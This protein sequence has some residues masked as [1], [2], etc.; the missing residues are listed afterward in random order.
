MVQNSGAAIQG[1]VV[2][3]ANPSEKPLASWKNWWTTADLQRCVSALRQ[4]VVPSSMPGFGHLIKTSLPIQS[5]DFQCPNLAGASEAILLAYP[6]SRVP[7]A[8]FFGDAIMLYNQLTNYALLGPPQPNPVKEQARRDM[9]LAEGKKLALVLSYL[10]RMASK[11]PVGS[12]PS[13]TYLKSLVRPRAPTQC[14][15][16]TRHL[17]GVEEADNL[18]CGDACENGKSG[19]TEVEPGDA[20]GEP[21]D[22]EDEGFMTDTDIGLRQ[23]DDLLGISAVCDGH[24]TPL[25]EASLMR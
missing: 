10:R 7:S 8:Y 2:I 11:T 19:D 22:A 23:L 9:A 6:T 17:L 16:N 15:P 14:S 1:A 25:A 21:D 13:M 24:S 12:T 18:G 3:M 4:R 5:I 20:E